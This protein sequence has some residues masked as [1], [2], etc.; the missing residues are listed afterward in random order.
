MKSNRV[1]WSAHVFEHLFTCERVT[2]EPKACSC[3][4]S[5]TKQAEQGNRFE[6]F[7]LAEKAF[8]S[9]SVLK[10]MLTSLVLIGDK[11]A[12]KMKRIKVPSLQGSKTALGLGML[13]QRSH[14]RCLSDLQRKPSD[15]MPRRVRLVGASI[16]TAKTTLSLAVP[17]K[18]TRS[19]HDNNLR[20]QLGQEHSG[21]HFR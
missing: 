2:K 18:S 12:A 9:L 15:F 3:A 20:D 19:R 16:T 21:L 4:V 7:L 6:D 10:G 1:S 5:S 13:H 17:E 11:F 8:P 14:P